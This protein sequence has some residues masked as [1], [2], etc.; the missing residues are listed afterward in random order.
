VK[1]SA[2]KLVECIDDL[3]CGKNGDAFNDKG[4]IVLIDMLVCERREKDLNI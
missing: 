3:K 4:C 2:Y 1:S